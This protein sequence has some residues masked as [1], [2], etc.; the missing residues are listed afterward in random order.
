MNESQHLST[1]AWKI[2]YKED[3]E[4]IPDPN[5]PENVPYHKAKRKKK[6]EDLQRLLDGPGKALFERWY[7]KLKVENLRLLFT[8]ESQLCT[9][10]T[11]NAIRQIRSILELWL[12]VEQTLL[13]HKQSKEVSNA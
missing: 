4:P 6:A 9:C 5:R 12:D 2:L 1:L 7:E 3:R 11:C 10:P 13:E 8:P